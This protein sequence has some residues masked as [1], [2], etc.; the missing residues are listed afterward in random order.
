MKD[1]ALVIGNDD[2]EV[3]VEK[4]NMITNRLKSKYEQQIHAQVVNSTWQGQNLKERIDDEH[5]V[6]KYFQWLQSWKLC[7][8]D[9]VHE[10]ALMFYQ[11]LPTRCYKKIRSNEEI[12]DIRC[13]LC[14]DDQESVKHI[15]SNCSTLAN[16]LYMKRH[17]NALKCFV[18]PLL[19]LF[20]LIEKTPTWYAND[21]LKPHYSKINVEFWWDVPEYT[22]RDTESIHPPRSDGKLMYSNETEK[23]IFLIEMT[24]PWTTNRREKMEYKES[25]YVSIQQ[26]LKFEYPDYQV[27][28][29]T[30]VM[31][32]YGGY[33][34]D[35]ADNIR[36]VVKDSSAIRS[37]ITNM[38]KSVIGSLA[39]MS[40]YFK[41]RCK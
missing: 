41:I 7:P 31:D 32:V 9:I 15:I 1:N 29:I 12:E 23:K 24:V 11:L 27:D 19:K 13:R 18:W 33:G 17:D 36:K 26:S 2:N 28:Q 35:L 16:S 21:E 37:I 25:K 4:M 6:K 40:R 39:N 5:V 34:K 22:G 20:E 14:N 10:F 3:I 38:Q 30:L 8:T